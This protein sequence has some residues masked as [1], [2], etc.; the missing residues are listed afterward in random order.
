M[1]G[2]RLSPI[3]YYDNFRIMIERVQSNER[4]DQIIQADPIPSLYQTIKQN[5]K[6][7]PCPNQYP[8]R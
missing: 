2:K 6:D 5:C 3:S 7:L 1:G 4:A 8:R